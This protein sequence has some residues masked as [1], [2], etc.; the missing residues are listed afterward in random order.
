MPVYHAHNLVLQTLADGGLVLV[1]ALASIVVSF[2][3]FLWRRRHQ[4]SRRSIASIAVLLGFGAASLLDDFSANPAIYAAV[5]TIA[6]W[7]IADLSSSEPRQ[8]VWISAARLAGPIV[9]LAGLSALPAVAS[10]D[11]ARSS[12]A[13]GVRAAQ[14][15][16]WQDAASAYQRAAVLHPEDAGYHLALGLSLF[17]LGEATMAGKEYETATRIAPGE[18]RA[19]GARA[20]LSWGVSS[21][22]IDWLDRASR[23]TVQDPQFSWRLADEQAKSG[24]LPAAVASYARAATLQPTLLGALSM[25]DTALSRHTVADALL[26]ELVRLASLE[27]LDAASVRLDAELATGSLGSDAPAA[28]QAVAEAERGHFSEATTLAGSAVSADPWRARGYLASAA[29]AWFRC[30]QSAFD[31]A[32]RLERMTVD[33]FTPAAWGELEPSFDPI[34][35]EI[36]LGDYQ[37]LETLVQAAREPW[38]LPLLSREPTCSWSPD[39]S[40]S[41]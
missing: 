9:V 4:L 12:A 23:L 25:T 28:W 15:E 22:E 11:L 36:G 17:H 38:P 40:A 3:V 35:R 1:A 2:C 5:V 34:Y 26:T 24:Q 41:R 7:L 18:A 19:W 14:S 21:D 31:H 27:R 37:P 29:V 16:N 8:G 32:M 39:F 33:H 10:I 6:A 30:D 20:A 13:E